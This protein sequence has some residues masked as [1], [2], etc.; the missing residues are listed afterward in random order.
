MGAGSNPAVA[1]QSSTSVVAAEENASGVETAPVGMEVDQAPATESASREPSTAR[2][3]GRKKS[4]ASSSGSGREPVPLVD[5][6]S[7]MV[8]YIVYF[9]FSITSI[10]DNTYVM[11]NS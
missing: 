3:E 5:Y 11:P 2:E 7:N 6:I 9:K 8:R 1:A 4:D 10:I